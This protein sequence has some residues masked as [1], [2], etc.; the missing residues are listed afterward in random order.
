MDIDD[1]IEE[2]ESAYE[3]AYKQGLDNIIIAIDTD[4]GETYHIKEV[5]EG[6]QCDLWD[7][8]FCDLYS[9]ACDLYDEISGTIVGVRVE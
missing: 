9:V 3:K 5:K 8:C 7:Y 4:C 6:F 2:V 1:F